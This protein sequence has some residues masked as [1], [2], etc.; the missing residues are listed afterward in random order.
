[1]KNK[2]ATAATAAGGWVLLCKPGFEAVLRKELALRIPGGTARSECG[3]GLVL[4]QAPL[5][6]GA[7]SSLGTPLIFER[8]RLPGAA[9]YPLEPLPR[10]A[11]TILAGLSAPA[12]LRE[13]PWALHAFAAD[14]NAPNSLAPWAVR[15]GAA[16]RKASAGLF[17]EDARASQVLQLCAVPGGA[18]AC[19]TAAASLSSPHPGGVGR[20]PP[21]P[22]APSRSYLKIEEALELLAVPPRAREK[23][24]DLGAAPGGW[25]YAFLKRG[26]RVLAVDNGP[27]KLNLDNL[28]GT[29]T[30]LRANGLT[31]QPPSGWTPVDWL[32]S[33]ML[34]SPGQCLGLLRGWLPQG[35][36][37]RF[38]VN[39]KLPQ[40]DPLVAL[41]PIEAFLAAQRGVKFQLRQL[42]H[43]RREVTAL[44]TVE[45]P[46]SGRARAAQRKGR[47]K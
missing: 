41:Q 46:Q 24:I 35:R 8:Q 30:H 13:A 7:G 1:M 6:Q 28:A 33:D 37:R 9:F 26:C 43:D 2:N 40:R 14:P 45:T 25:S 38:V 36:A 32:V 44:G 15:L 18:W 17:A 47:P 39:I 11:G 12:L 5:P 22:L 31:F 19:L 29:L 16:L 23:V 34:I 4:L 20:M 27:I 21:D 42:Y 10:L 3:K